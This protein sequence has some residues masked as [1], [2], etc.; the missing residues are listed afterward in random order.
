M[1]GTLLFVCS[2]YAAAR[3][4]TVLFTPAKLENVDHMSQM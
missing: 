1:A 2:L 3:A 4:S